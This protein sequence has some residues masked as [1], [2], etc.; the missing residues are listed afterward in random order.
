MNR[1]RFYV[2]MK[3]KTGSEVSMIAIKKMELIFLKFS[4]GYTRFD[5]LGVWEGN[6]EESEVFEVIGKRTTEEALEVAAEIAHV[7]NQ[8]AVLVTVE[9]INA[10][11]I[12][13]GYRPGQEVQAGAV[14]GRSG[15]TGL[16]T[17]PHL[18]YEV[19]WAGHPLNP[20]RYLQLNVFT[21]SRTWQ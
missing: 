1:I 4:P 15:S 5:T 9:P 18:H 21:A 19:K 7:M 16:S 3:D 11:F 2:G 13:A 20:M 12:A 17:G 8:T 10:Y 6:T 14:I